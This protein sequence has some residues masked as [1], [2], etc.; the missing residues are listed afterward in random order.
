LSVKQKS[1]LRK[2]LMPLQASATVK[3]DGEEDYYR[4]LEVDSAVSAKELKKTYYKLVVQYHPDN[5]PNA[6]PAEKE[7]L[8]RQMMVINAAYKVLKSPELRPQYDMKR[9][10]G[11][12]GSA[13]QVKDRPRSGT[14]S[15]SNSNSNSNTNS[16]SSSA[17]SSTSTSSSSS[18]RSSSTSGG[19]SDKSYYSSSSSRQS[20]GY[21]YSPR[22][23]EAADEPVESYYDIMSD[24]WAELTSKNGGSI[25]EDAISYLESQ[26]GLLYIC[27]YSS[28]KEAA[29]SSWR[30]LRSFLRS[31]QG[32][33][34]SGASREVAGSF[35]KSTGGY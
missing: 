20:T 11:Q 32:F 28:T 31:R 14:N 27:I 1:L 16:E 25:M 19:S 34:L 3:L 6:T 10:M 21:T 24:L 2:F 8:N 4:V 7:V 12:V 26:V 17:R 13:A 29:G 5:K 9:R 18:S 35:W 30:F 23:D 22:D 33:L 15:N